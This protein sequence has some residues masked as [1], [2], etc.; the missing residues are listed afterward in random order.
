M[1]CYLFPE[2]KGLAKPGLLSTQGKH[3]KVMGVPEDVDCI[4]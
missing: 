2:A 1:F 4:G 3:P